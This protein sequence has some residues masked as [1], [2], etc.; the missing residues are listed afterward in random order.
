MLSFFSYFFYTFFLYIF[1]YITRQSSTCRTKLRKIVKTF[2]QK[3]NSI[4]SKDY[5][6]L[7]PKTSAYVY[8]YIY[9]FS[10]IFSTFF[11]TCFNKIMIT[12]TLTMILQK[13][14]SL[15]C[16]N[17]KEQTE[18]RTLAKTLPYIKCCHTSASLYEGRIQISDAEY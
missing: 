5:K 2:R 10:A 16:Q 3:N 4:V 8:I 17:V 7:N 12:W 13:K 14:K 11:Y 9:F 1:L 15:Y 6:K 18:V